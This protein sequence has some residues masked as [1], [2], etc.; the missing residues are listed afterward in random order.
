MSKLTPQHEQAP[1]GTRVVD[2]VDSYRHAPREQAR[3]TVEQVPAQREPE[4]EP[5][6]VR[7]VN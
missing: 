2:A 7:S 4:D 5:H 6:I 1:Q 3:T